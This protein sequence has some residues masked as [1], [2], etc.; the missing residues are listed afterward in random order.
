MTRKPNFAKLMLGVFV[1]VLLFI[2]TLAVTTAPRAGART[3]HMGR[4]GSALPLAT[5]SWNAVFEIE[6]N[7]V[8]DSGAGLPDDWN[9]LNPGDVPTTTSTSVTGSP[10]NSITATFISDPAISTDLIYT[11]GSSKDFNDIDDWGQVAKGTGP[12]KDDIQHAYAAKYINA[13]DGHSILVFGGDRGTNNGDANLGFWFF[14]DAVGPNNSGG[15]DGLHT[16]GDVF[17]LSAFSGGGG[18]STIR[19]LVWVGTPDT[20]GPGGTDSGAVARCATF[21]NGTGVIDPK[22]DTTEFPQGSLCDITGASPFAGTGITNSEPVAV[23]W[24]YKNVDSTQGGHAPAGSGVDCSTPNCTIPQ[25]DF[26]E[27]VIDLNELGLA[28][29]CFASFLLETRSSAEVSAV[30]KDFALGNFEAC[31]STCGKSASPTEVCEDPANPGFGLP[32]ALTFETTNTGGATLHETLKDDNGTP[33]DTSDD[34]YITGGLTAAPAA[35]GAC[36]TNASPT[37][38]EIG[39]GVT[40]RCTLSNVVDPVGTTT[41]TLTVHEVNGLVD[42]CTQ[43]ATVIVHPLPSCSITGT[44]IICAGGST[45]F[46]GPSGMSTYSWTGPGGFIASTQSTGSI[47]EA[48]TYELTITDDNGCSSTCSRTLTVNPLPTCNITGTNEICQKDADGNTNTTEFCGPAGM[49]VYAWTGPGGFTKATQCTGNIS[50]AGTY[51]LTITDANGCSSSCSRTLTVNANP[52]VTIDTVACDLDGSIV[53]HSVPSGGSGGYTYSWDGGSA[54]TQDI[55]VT[56]TGSHTVVVTDSN[57]CA[58][59]QAT[60]RV[61]LCAGP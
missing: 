52:S 54:T 39:A 38:I 35:P 13:T 31:S 28:S 26:F 37:T 56:A 53:L 45:S 4:A 11:G 55:T 34:F 36:E 19:V 2:G 27:G 17:V 32:V 43:T 9:D 40:L 3:V 48:G 30:L 49:T 6:G 8:D 46:S 41:D 59:A 24:Q 61:G 51:D 60:I 58:S 29:E 1:L 33:G 18:T 44:N 50:T 10:G 5:P 47:S 42:D 22:S 14:Q 20:A 21:G 7:A 57:G 16:N 15:F 25:P 12:P 23:S